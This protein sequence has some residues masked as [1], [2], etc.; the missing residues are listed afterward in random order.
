MNEW[1]RK[2]FTYIDREYIKRMDLPHLLKVGLISFRRHIYIPYQQHITH[3]ILQLI[4]LELQQSN[5]TVGSSSN[6]N[7]NKGGTITTPVTDKSLVKYII[8]LYKTMSSLTPPTILNV[9][10][11]NINNNN[12]RNNIWHPTHTP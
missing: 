7:S 12:I 8:D 2:F 4:A 6:N 5:K 3:A 11:N 10:V 1:L 9:N